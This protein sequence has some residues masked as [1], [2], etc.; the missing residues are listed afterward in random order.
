MAMIGVY[1]DVIGTMLTKG[2]IGNSS[3]RYF[4]LLSLSVVFAGLIGVTINEPAYALKTINDTSGGDCSA[5][6]T[7]SDGTRTC[8]LGSDLSEGIV[9]GS[10]NIILDGN[11]HTI[12][13]SNTGDGILLDI[14]TGVTV[15]NLTIKNFNNGI[16][17]NNAINVI[18]IGNTISGN[19]KLNN[20]G[21]ETAGSGSGIYAINSNTISATDNTISNN[22]GY[23]I[24]I[25]GSNSILTGNTANNNDNGISTDGNGDTL[26][27]NTASGNNNDGIDITGSY[28]LT[29]NTAS[30]NNNDGIL[31]NGEGTLTNNIAS[32][33]NNGIVLRGGISVLTG[34]LISNN[35]NAGINYNEV[36]YNSLVIQNTISN[37]YYGIYGNGASKILYYNNNFINNA[38]QVFGNN[39]ASFYKNSPVGGNYW[40]DWSTICTDANKDNFCDSPYPFSS[41]SVNVVDNLPWVIKDGWLTTITTG[42]NITTTTTDSSGKIVSYTTS[43]KNGNSPV[44][45][46]CTPSSGSVFLMGTTNVICKADN[47]VYASFSVTV[48]QPD[49]TPPVV[50]PPQN[51]VITATNSQGAIVNYPVPTVTDNIGVTSGPTCTPTSGSTFPV[52][53]TTVTCIAADAA[54]NVGT[55]TFMVTVQN[56]GQ[57]SSTITIP[58]SLRTIAGE[59][60]SNQISDSDFLQCPIFY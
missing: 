15:K 29:G 14:K 56:T 8:T 12:T 21:Y 25:S 52:G 11:G 34:N 20:G 19:V 43:A 40:S 13:G 4:I 22:A 46:T 39:Y 7:W 31:I 49:T 58:S 16:N 35:K 38:K 60:S 42:G 23:G 59:W 53:S 9:I 54:G 48:K 37:N 1:L 24:S 32:N 45:V 41:G 6:G 50:T 33:N 30:G 5:I 44:P 47:G 10:N 17:L 18:L 3:N 2:L 28:T 36:G 26:T 27:G 51:Q 57:T 55:A